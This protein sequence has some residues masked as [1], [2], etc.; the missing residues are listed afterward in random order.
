MTLGGSIL[1][2][3]VEDLVVLA[4]FSIVFAEI[5]RRIVVRRLLARV[6]RVL[7]A[8]ASGK[9]GPE[10]VFG[11]NV[12]W[13]AA[14]AVLALV[15][16]GD[17]SGKWHLTVAAKDALKRTIGALAENVKLTPGGGA[18]GIGGGLDLANLDLDQLAGVAIWQLP[19]KQQGIAAMAYTIVKPIAVRILGG[20]GGEKTSEKKTT[21]E[22][23]FL[24]DLLK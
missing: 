17:A 11:R 24:K 12:L 19:K 10:A 16:V 5:Y 3:S 14:Q 7:Q 1:A 20:L 15:V 23:P 4:L 13:M 8:V 9:D 22:N 2:V 21:T 18:P 6:V